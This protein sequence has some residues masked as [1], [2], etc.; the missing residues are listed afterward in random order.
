MVCDNGSNMCKAGFARD[1]ASTDVFPST[2][3]HQNSSSMCN[4]DFVGHDAPTDVFTYINGR[5]SH[6]ETMVGMEQGDSD[7]QENILTLE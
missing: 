3:K 4:N 7:S 1:D 6:Q 5:P 2:V